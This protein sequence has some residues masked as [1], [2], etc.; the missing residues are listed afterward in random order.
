MRHI[1][2]WDNIQEAG[3]Y[4]NPAPGAYLARMTRVEDREDKEYL[5]IE[6]DFAEGAYQGAN[7]ETYDRAGFWPTVLIRSY[8]EKA[9]PFFKGFKTAV[10]QSNPGYTFDDRSPD[11]LVGRIV[12]VVLGEEAYVKSNGAPG[13]RLYV[14]ETRSLD[15]IRRGDFTV[16]PFKPLSSGGSGQAPAQGPAFQPM[17]DDDGELP[18]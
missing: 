10:E 15:A 6:W 4:D 9:L 5:R 2:N 17:E 18:F 14:A 11:G 8:K 12:G 7:R 3:S 1:D 13:R 16:P